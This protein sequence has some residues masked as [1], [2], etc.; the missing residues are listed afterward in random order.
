MKKLVLTVVLAAST[1]TVGCL[2]PNNLTN[3]LNN[4]NAEATS[5]NWLN[6]L[7]F[8]PLFPVQGLTWFADVLVLNT[9]DYW[10]GK[11]IVTE[12]GTFPAAFTYK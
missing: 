11:N 2:G 12:P 3:K 5:M 6:E 8:I 1:M 7:I 10:T 9:I 4:W